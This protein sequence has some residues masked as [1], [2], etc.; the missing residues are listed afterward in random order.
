MR[1]NINGCQMNF[2]VRERK[3]AP[4]LTLSHALANDLTLWDDVVAA[5]G[6]RYSILRYDQR[7]HGASEATPAGPYTFPMLVGDAISLL[8]HV[9][10]DKTNWIGLSIGG[11]IG[12]GLA[13]DHGDRLN[14]LIACDSRSDA[15]PDYAAY[16]QSRIDKAREY[17]MEGVV[18]STIERWFTPASVAANPPALDKVRKMIRST[19]P[20][21]HEGC[22][23]ALKTLSFGSRCP[24]IRV[25]TLILGGAED[26]GAPPEKLA[27]VAAKIPG[28]RQVVIP[29]AG[30]ITALE[31]PDAFMA[32]VAKFLEEQ[33]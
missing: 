17:G 12:Y 30:H 4:W 6:D 2:E 16:F 5:L 27:E 33:A 22:C 24:E 20:A 28:A 10:I 18:E 32:E 19:S 26:K 7:G 23:E 1:T 21:G 15:P 31:N 29:A 14:S 25:P 11:M 8:D 3:G 9:G 13:I